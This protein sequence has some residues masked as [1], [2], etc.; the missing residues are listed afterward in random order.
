MNTHINKPRPER[1]TP[2]LIALNLSF[3]AIFLLFI[4][5]NVDQGL[6]REYVGQPLTSFET[7]K[8]V[9]S[10]KCAACHNLLFDAEGNSLSILNHWRSSVMANAAKDPFW[11]AK[12]SSEAARNPAIKEIIE[13]KCVTCHMPMAKVEAQSTGQKILFEPGFL[14]PIHGLHAAAMDGVSCSFCHQIED[15]NLG[16]SKSFSGKFKIDEKTARPDRQ[17]YGPY[18]N[19]DQKTM[20]TSVGYKPV[21]G[22]HMATSEFCATCHTLFTPY[23]DGEGNIAGEFPE[24]TAYLEWQNSK[25]GDNT[26]DDLSC[27]ECHMP[28]PDESVQISRYAPSGTEKRP[29]FSQHHFVGSNIQMLKL[30]KDNLQLLGLTTSS[31]ELEDTL[32][33]TLKQLQEKTAQLSVLKANRLGDILTT[34]IEIQ[35]AT[36]HKFP[37]GIPCRRAWIH[38]QVLDVNG[39]TVFESG[40]PNEDGS[41]SGNLNDQQIQEYEPHYEEIT[42][43]DQVQI[44]ET[45]MANTDGKVTYTLL[46][47]AGYLKDNRLLPVGFEKSSAEKSI[48]VYGKAMDDTSFQG[49]SDHIT[50]KIPTNG[51]QGPFTVKADLL[52][53]ALSFSFLEDLKK[54][55]LPLV[56]A[57]FQYWRRT[58]KSPTVISSTQK[59][60]SAL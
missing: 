48:G 37:T 58:D 50:Y 17:I 56:H 2:V 14:E 41:I 38:L 24:Q 30:M 18:N 23:L 11:Q 36:G 60:V 13:E 45:I 54:D 25:F 27:Q 21:H 55:D 9:G 51:A 49:G 1:Q 39:N 12:V 28:E 42:T 19:V 8:F 31:Q 33:R 6:T 26:K 43:A 32:Q 22:S 59:E 47:A 15:S 34:E 10:E 44:Y 5:T 46:R 29:N 40:K 7:E 16:N 35:S 57:F 20:Q 4:F 3:L 52:Y 53:T